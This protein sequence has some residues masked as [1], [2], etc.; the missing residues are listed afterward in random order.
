MATQSDKEILDLIGVGLGP[1]NLGLAAM[2]AGAP[3]VKALFLEQKPR[4]AW[5]PGL[6]IEGTTL[7][8][9]F[10]ADLVTMADPTSRYSFLNYLKERNRLYHFYFLERFHIPRREYNHYCQWVSEQLDICC[11]GQKVTH[12]EWIHDQRRR[13]FQ[14]EATDTHTGETLVYRTRHLVLGVGS[15]PHLHP[16][17][18]GLPAEDVFHSAR[19]LDRLD[20]CRKAKSI[21]VIGSGQSAAEVFYILLQEQI[22]YGYRLDWFTRSDGFFPMEYSKLGLEHFSPDYTSYFYSLPQHQRDNRLRQQDL[23]YKGISAKTI[24]DI[25]D[26]LYERT[27]GEQEIPARLLAQTEVQEIQPL[28]TE[29]NPTYRL[30]CLHRE[31][32]KRFTHD[33]EVVILATGYQHRIPECISGLSSLIRWDSGGRYVVQSDYRLALNEDTDN[34]IFVQNGELHTHGVG[35][36]DL[37]LGAYRNSVIINT[38]TGRDIYPVHDRNV[39]QQFGVPESEQEP[40]AFLQQT[41][42]L[43]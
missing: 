28:K 11:F 23:L 31:Q 30:H 15:V 39:Y 8:V 14:V 16:R 36:P 5:H 4:F 22:S 7:Q 25:Y 34:M 41:S 21:T 20:R 12:I 19:F 29:G 32:A 38:L 24:A 6:L 3:E 40:A 10:L 37:G 43:R 1:F 18:K 27:V 35:A 13:Y 33:S 9:P 17:F 26:L 2:L 42:L